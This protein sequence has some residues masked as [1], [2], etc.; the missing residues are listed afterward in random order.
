M[1]FVTSV[2]VVLMLVVARVERRLRHFEMIVMLHQKIIA[3][4]LFLLRRSRLI[5]RKSGTD[6]QWSVV[7]WQ[8]FTW[9]SSLVT[10]SSQCVRR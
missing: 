10:F 9:I 7:R 5:C 3:A 8:I 1:G 4:L 6:S 2:I